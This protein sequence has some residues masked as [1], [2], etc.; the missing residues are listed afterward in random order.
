MS[1]PRGEGSLAVPVIRV[2]IDAQMCYPAWN[3]G[4]G[5]RASFL[6][7]GFYRKTDS[8][9]ASILTSL[10]GDLAT[11]SQLANRTANF[12]EDVFERRMDDLVSQWGQYKELY[13]QPPQPQMQP[14]FSSGHALMPTMQPTYGSVQGVI[15]ISDS[16]QAVIVTPMQVQQ[17]QPVQTVQS[18]S[19][20]VWVP[21]GTSPPAGYTSLRIKGKLYMP[22]RYNRIENVPTAECIVYEDRQQIPSEMKQVQHV[23]AFTKYQINGTRQ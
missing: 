3:G 17:P 11:L 5:A 22:K 2:P 12:Q 4:L 21:D 13:S 18:P 7:E 19:P 23:R 15:P 16:R 8:R 1:F 10:K 20:Y 6:P 14:S 9:A